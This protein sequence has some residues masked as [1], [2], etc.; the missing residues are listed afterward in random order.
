MRLAAISAGAAV[1]TERF[2]GVVHSVFRQACNIRTGRDGLLTLLGSTLGNAPYGVRVGLP[3]GLAF[4]DRLRPGQRVGCRA[5]VLRVAGGDFA[6]DLG[7]AEVWRCELGSPCI[8]LARAAVASAWQTAWQALAR[9]CRR[10][11]V[12]PLT[13]SVHLGGWALAHASRSRCAPAAAAAIGRLIGRGPGLTPAG[14]DLIVGFLAG[15]WS[16]RGDD[17]AR[18]RFLDRLAAIVDGAAAATG[19]ISRAHLRHATR[20]SVAEPLARLGRAIGEGDPPPEVGRAAGMALSVG[21]TSGGDG[22][23]GL[24]LGIACWSGRLTG[25]ELPHG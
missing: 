17:P 2:T 10:L 18:R 11:G 5:A 14:D 15:L 1:P 9:H 4:S 3:A 21:H 7:A 25:R 24:L 12:D 6:V 13:D 8:D 22:V 19:E 20:G 16:T 23:F